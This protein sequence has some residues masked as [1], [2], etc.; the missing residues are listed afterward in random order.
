MPPRQER[1]PWWRWG[2]TSSAAAV[3]VVTLADLKTRLAQQERE[4]AAYRRAEAAG[5][6]SVSQARQV[7]ASILVGYTMGLQRLERALTQHEVEPIDC[8]G[9]S[10]DPE[11]MEVVEVVNEP[12][13][14]GTEVIEEVRRGYLWRGRLFAPP[15]FA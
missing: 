2:R 11:S 5:G 6:P 12:G 10:F 4:L 3:P 15:R 8:V 13:R 14:E 1:R 7:L 9:E